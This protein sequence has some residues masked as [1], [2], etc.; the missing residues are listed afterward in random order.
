MSLPKSQK[1]QFKSGEGYK[2]TQEDQE[3]RPRLQTSNDYWS[4]AGTFVPNSQIRP[5]F[6]P[7]RFARGDAQIQEKLTPCYLEDMPAS[8]DEN[9]RPAGPI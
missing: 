7:K 2:R 1:N 9:K 4:S 3:V 6:K 5:L 8:N